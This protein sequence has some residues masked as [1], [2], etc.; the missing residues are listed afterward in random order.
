MDKVTAQAGK[1]YMPDGHFFS[2]SEAGACAIKGTDTHPARSPK[3]P[4]LH[5]IKEVPFLRLE[6]LFGD[7]TQVS[8]L[9]QLLYL[10]WDVEG[11]GLLGA[12]S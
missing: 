12:P 11:S 7:R 3:A 2:G 1:L 10:S 5:T 9:R 6:L 8:E 4:A